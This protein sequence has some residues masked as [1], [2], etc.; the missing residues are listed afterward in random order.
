MEPEKRYYLAIVRPENLLQLVKEKLA[1]Y[2]V[3]RDVKS[4]KAGDRILLYKSRGGS[5]RG[6]SGSSGIVGAFEVTEEPRPPS[7][8]ADRTMFTALYP[9][10]IPW[11]A[12]VTSLDEPLSIAPLVPDLQMFPNKQKYGSA[13]QTTMKMLNSHDYE[14]LEDALRRHVKVTNKESRA[15]QAR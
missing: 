6:S 2:A 15:Y 13:L 4:L 9:T 10:R 12:I 5:G 14:M 8:A 7:R 3:K 1:F 11:R